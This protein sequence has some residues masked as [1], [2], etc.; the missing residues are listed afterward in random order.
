MGSSE[1]LDLGADAA[2][3]DFDAIKLLA[4]GFLGLFGIAGAAFGLVWGFSR[5]LGEMVRQML[6]SA[7]E[8]AQDESSGS[9]SGVGE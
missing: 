3:G 9:W 8:G 2:Q 4:L 6:S 1:T 5:G 7:A